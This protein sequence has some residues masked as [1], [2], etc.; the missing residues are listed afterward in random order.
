MI[1]T[2]AHKIDKDIT[3]ITGDSGVGKDLYFSRK[4]AKDLNIK[5]DEIKFNYQHDIIK[6]IENMT[7]VFEVPLNLYGQ[8]V[9]M[10]ILYEKVS[11]LGIRVLLDGSGGDE[12]YSG[13]FHR[14]S[15]H[16]I[17]SLIKN[18]DFNQLFQFIFYGIEKIFFIYKNNQIPRWIHTL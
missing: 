8:V 13:Y 10:N 1:S 3:F 9:A 18:R 7:R 14:Y 6:R 4:L 15:Q 2:I 16:F 5:L 11:N 17:N 12:I